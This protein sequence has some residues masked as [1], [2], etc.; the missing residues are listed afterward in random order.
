MSPFFRNGDSPD[1]DLSSEIVPRVGPPDDQVENRVREVEHL[2]AVAKVRS[3]FGFVVAVVVVVHVTVVCAVTV[4]VVVTVVFV[5]VVVVVTVFVLLQLLQLSL[6]SLLS[7]CCALL[8][9]V[10]LVLCC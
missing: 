3:I 6:L 8:L 4:V 5:V 2:D 10:L 9:Q 1:S 7:W